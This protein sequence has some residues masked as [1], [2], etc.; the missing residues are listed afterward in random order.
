MKELP[1]A[2]T[3][4]IDTEFAYEKRD[5]FDCVTALL[6]EGSAAGDPSMMYLY[7]RYWHYTFQG[8]QITEDVYF[9]W[10]LAEQFLGI[11]L[12][13]YDPAAMRP[14]V[15]A[16][17]A[18]L[19]D[20]AA[21]AGSPRAALWRAYRYGDDALLRDIRELPESLEFPELMFLPDAWLDLERRCNETEFM[22]DLVAAGHPD[23]PSWLP[24]PG[25]KSLRLGL[26]ELA[27]YGLG[28]G[29][30]L[31]GAEHALDFDGWSDRHR[32]FGEYV[33]RTN[34][35]WQKWYERFAFKH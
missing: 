25:W 20:S 13:A 14:R 32:A 34:G 17:I 3:G 6:R 27:M 1:S 29:I 4:L 11:G 19:F 8:A 21:R 12:D 31:S 10:E 28:L 5:W 7:G 16:R 15:D 35:D 23:D 30:D 2:Q 22:E 18:G 33:K 24:D 9:E 26:Y